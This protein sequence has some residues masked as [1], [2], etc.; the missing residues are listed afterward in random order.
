MAAMHAVEIADGEDG[1]AEGAG[2]MIMAVDDLH[3]V[4]HSKST[5]RPSYAG[6]T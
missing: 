2:H 6:R 5:V 4:H 1:A 3:R